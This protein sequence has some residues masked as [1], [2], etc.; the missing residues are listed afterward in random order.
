MSEDKSNENVSL[1]PD[2]KSDASLTKAPLII[3]GTMVLMSIVTIAFVFVTHYER[4]EPYLDSKL[5][6]VVYKTRAPATT[7]S[8]NYSAFGP[9]VLAHTLIGSQ[10]WQWQAQ[11][12]DD[13]VQTYDIKIVVYRTITEK[14]VSVKFP[15]IEEKYMDYRYLPLEDAMVYLDQTI[16]EIQDPTI[17]R[18]LNATRTKLADHFR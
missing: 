1:A 17:R 6:R 2:E 5:R 15:I 13:P 7:L 10:W 16:N 18:T 3:F 14:E 9:Q 12:S 8:L 11:G 4:T